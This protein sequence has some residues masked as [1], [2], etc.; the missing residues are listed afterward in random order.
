MRIWMCI[1]IFVFLLPL[2]GYGQQVSLETTLQDLIRETSGLVFMDRRIITHNDSGGE[3][4]LY[5]VDSLSGQVTRSV[6]LG[7]A[8]NM[9]W[10]DICFD[11]AYIYI[12]DFGNNSGSRTDLKIYRL[13]ISDYLLEDTVMVDTIRFSYADQ[14]DFSQGLNSTDYDAEALISY[15]DQ[16]YIFTKNWNNNWTYLYKLPK[17]PGNYQ[18]EKTDS[19]NAQGLV[20]GATYN[21]RSGKILL[22]GYAFVTPFI[23]EISDIPKEGF[24]GGSIHRYP[25]EL[26]PGYSPQVEGIASINQTDYYLTAEE[27]FLGG[28]VLYR[29]RTDVAVRDQPDL[30]PGANIYPNPASGMVRIDCVDFSAVDIYDLQGTLLRSSANKSLNIDDLSKGVYILSIK[31]SAE[32]RVR[33]EKLIIK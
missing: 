5:E 17:I 3:P 32:N 6:A 29:L 4:A 28:P 22:A 26:E 33:T 19:I 15:Q 12:A 21:A 7:N 25:L 18:V 13:S 23:I 9:D 1:I 27:N 14:K 31:N 30:K 2:S 20:T 11:S 10:E 8:T 16:L 24:P